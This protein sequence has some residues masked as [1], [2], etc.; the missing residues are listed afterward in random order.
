MKTVEDY[1]NQLP[2]AAESIDYGMSGY[3]QNGMFCGF[4]SQKQYRNLYL[5]NTPIFKEYKDVF[6]H[7]SVGKGTIRL[8]NYLI[9]Y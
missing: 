8:K 4:A 1:L 7:L 2:D 6:V 5:L 3:T 9:C